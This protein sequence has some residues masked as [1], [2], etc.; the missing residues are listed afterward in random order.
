MCPGVFVALMMK[1][2]STQYLFLF[3]LAVCVLCSFALA[4]I[5]EGLRPLREKNEEMDIKKNI[6]RAADIRGLDIQGVRAEELLRIYD[7]NIQEIVIDAQGA[8]V[9]KKSPADIQDGESQYPVYIYRGSGKPEAYIFPVSGK[10][11][12]STIYGFLALEKNAVTIRGVTFYKH[13]E[14]PGLGG[15]VEADWFQKN[16]KGKKIYDVKQGR[17]RPVQV[18][19]G[20]VEEKFSGRDVHFAVDGISGATMTSKGVSAFLERWIRL[21]NPYFENIRRRH[22]ANT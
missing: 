8:V 1:K 16:F 22:A 19:Q 10:G 14:T 6:L 2:D 13:G 17:L 21:Y 11:L 20:N 12:W 3:A 4:L 15:E 5:S 9:L 7:E 18:I